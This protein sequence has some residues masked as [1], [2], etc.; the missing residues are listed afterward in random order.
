MFALKPKFTDKGNRFGNYVRKSK[1]FYVEATNR[2]HAISLI[3][4]KYKREFMAQIQAMN[5]TSMTED[6][7]NFIRYVAKTRPGE[8]AELF[9]FDRT[10]C[11]KMN[12][13]KALEKMGVKPLFDLDD[14]DDKP[15]EK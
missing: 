11:K 5:L 10:V 13:E 8:K 3:E 2:Q 7:Y 4:S 9:T 1:F 14:L 12:P 15:K 6:D